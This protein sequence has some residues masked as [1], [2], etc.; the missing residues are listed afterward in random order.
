MKGGRRDEGETKVIQNSSSVP[1]R[2]LS[3]CN[4]H[5]RQQRKWVRNPA[6]RDYV[7]RQ[8]LYCRC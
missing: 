3:C 5:G 8:H 7:G 6:L 4:V 2:V 1:R